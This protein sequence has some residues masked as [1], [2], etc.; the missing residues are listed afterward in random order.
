MAYKSC[1]S[2]S[3]KLRERESQGNR[4]GRKVLTEP[5]ATCTHALSLAAMQ[6]PRLDPSHRTYRNPPHFFLLKTKHPGKKRLFNSQMLPNPGLQD[7]HAD[8]SQL[9]LWHGTRRDNCIP[10]CLRGCPSSLQLPSPG[11]HAQG[12]NSSC[13][14]GFFQ[15]AASSPSVHMHMCHA[16]GKRFHGAFVPFLTLIVPSHRC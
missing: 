16:M 11:Q 7:K 6:S 10:I 9:K 3:N 14:E 8:A 1:S 2:N 5:H 4:R 15:R 13:F 12:C